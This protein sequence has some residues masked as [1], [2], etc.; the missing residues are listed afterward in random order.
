MFASSI[1]LLLGGGSSSTLSL[2]QPYKRLW[3]KITCY[4]K[5]RVIILHQQ[6]DI[7]KLAQII[8]WEKYFFKWTLATMAIYFIAV[9][10]VA[11]AATI[12][13]Y[14]FAQTK[15]RRLFA[16]SVLK[17]IWVQGHKFFA[18]KT[19]GLSHYIGVQTAEKTQD[20]PSVDSVWQSVCPDWTD[21]FKFAAANFVVVNATFTRYQCDQIG[22]SLMVVG[23]KFSYQSGQLFGT[24]FKF[25]K[26]YSS[27]WSHCLSIQICKHSTIVYYACRALRYAIFSHVKY[28]CWKLVRFATVASMV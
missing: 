8:K 24:F 14:N 12:V 15:R 21:F 3:L 5:V 25:W 10:V 27:I 7:E 17:V 20:L 6:N 19:L 9:V 16:D 2:F 23:T 11:V 26:K 22:I 28:N 13:C 4:F 18:T 1:L